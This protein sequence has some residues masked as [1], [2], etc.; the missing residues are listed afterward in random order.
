MKEHENKCLKKVK[1]KNKLINY[2]IFLYFKIINCTASSFM[3]PWKGK[4]EELS[5]HQIECPYN[6]LYPILDKM[7]KVFNY[8]IFHFHY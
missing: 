7:I 6:Q 3:C 1:L 2:L 4:K 5:K 8:L